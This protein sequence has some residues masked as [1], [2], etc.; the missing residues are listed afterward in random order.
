M[1][2][3]LKIF[4][5]FCTDSASMNWALTPPSNGWFCLISPELVF[6]ERKIVFKES[7]KNSDFYRNSTG[8]KFALLVQP[9]TSPCPYYPP[10]TT[11]HF[12]RKLAKMERKTLAVRLSNIW[13][14]QSPI[15]SPPF[16][17]KYD[18]FLPLFGL[19]L[20]INRA[21]SFVQG[22]QSKYYSHTLLQSCNSWAT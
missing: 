1:V 4:K 20:A 16:Q 2:V 12:S 10:P 7:F 19:F 8:T 9:L 11:S 3:R 18:Y 21:W 14:K 22:S 13:Q 15:S 17:E 5:V 6:K